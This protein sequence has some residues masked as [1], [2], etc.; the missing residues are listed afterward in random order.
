MSEKRKVF[1]IC[2]HFL[3][4]EKMETLLVGGVETY[5]NNLISIILECGMEPVVIQHAN[6]DKCV[7]YKGIDVYGV[8]IQG[9][10]EKY[11]KK[12]LYQQYK[13][14][15]SKGNNIILYAS[16]QDTFKRDKAFTMAIQHGIEWDVQDDD[17]VNMIKFLLTFIRKVVISLKRIKICSYVDYL[18]C[19]DYN[20]INWFRT[21]SRYKLRNYRCIPNFSKIPEEMP[22]KEKN[23][24]NIIFARRF[25]G[26]RGTIL[27]AEAIK[28]VLESNKNVFV[29]IAGTG[30]DENKMR[31]I[32]KDYDNVSFIKYH[33]EDSQKIHSDK[34]IAVVPTKGSEGTSLSLLEAMASGCAVIATNVGGMTNIIIDGYNG[35]LI[36]PDVEELKNV[37]KELIENVQR[38]E[39]LANNAY[40][41]VKYGFS[42]TIWR[43]KWINVFEEIKGALEGEEPV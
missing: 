7:K 41:S 13:K 39:I 1:I 30:P 21:L 38:R 40:D 43:K 11:R 35:R 27:F 22:Q 36:N 25:V 28:E 29:T 8:N 32:L 5:I 24:V 37:L 14:L 34:H 9:V 20:F 19:V 3:D 42:H 6:Y 4:F 23:I 15:N 17:E 16:E 2:R 31:E 18:V 33:S 26:F 10:K 12:L